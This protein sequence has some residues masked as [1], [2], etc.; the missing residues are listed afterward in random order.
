[1]SRDLDAQL[2]ESVAVRRA[3]LREALLWGR[4]RRVRAT[5]DTLK[6]LAVGIVVAAVVAAGCVGWSFVNHL[7]AGQARVTV[8]R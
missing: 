1:M 2:L 7:I 3:R 6:R 5:G 8:T 4:D